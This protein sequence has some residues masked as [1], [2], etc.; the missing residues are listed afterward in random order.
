[1]GGEGL[2]TCLRSLAPEET[3]GPLPGTLLELRV[4]SATRAGRHL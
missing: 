4:G 1:M 3:W 2:P